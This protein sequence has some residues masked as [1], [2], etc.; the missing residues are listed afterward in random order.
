MVAS[1]TVWF[2]SLPAI[3]QAFIFI[4]AL[5]TVLMVIPFYN[6]RTLNYGPTALTMIGIF[7]CFLGISLGLMDF[8]TGDIQPR[9][10]AI[11]DC[12]ITNSRV[13]RVRSCDRRMF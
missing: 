3:T 9:L 1:L 2:D 4:I 10:S 12:F 5:M 7:G 13:V 11:A 6:N 8:K